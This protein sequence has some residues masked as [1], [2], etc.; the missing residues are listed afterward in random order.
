[1]A[2]LA[3]VMGAVSA[4]ADPFG[5]GRISGE[6]K[7][8]RVGSRFFGL[9]M[10]IYSPRWPQL[11]VPSVRM[12]TRW[13]LVEQEPGRYDWT[14]LDEQVQAAQV[15]GARPLLI[16][17]GTP[18][19]HSVNANPQGANAP[20]LGAYR[21]FVEALVA[22]YGEGV[23]YQ[24]WNEPN[25][26][27]F[28]SGTPA[29]AAEMT[30]LLAR[31]VRAAAPSATVVAPSF[32]LRGDHPAFRKWFRAYL[33]QTVGPRER[34]V[35]QFFDA[36][37][38]SA[39]PMPSGDPEDGLAIIRYARNVLSRHGFRGPVW[40]SE[41][42]YGAN[43]GAPAKAVPVRTQVSNVVR[44]YVLHATVG[45]DRVFWY[46]WVPDQTVNTQL[47]NGSGDL[48]PAGKAFGTVQTWLRSGK[49]LG[50]KTTKGVSTCG[51]R[52]GGGVKRY[53]SWTRSGRIRPLVAPEGAVSL[54]YPTSKARSLKPGRRLHVGVTP[55]MIE[56]QPA[57]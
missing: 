18:P 6:P 12:G 21:A 40:A 55:V 43:G 52:V 4:S 2:A 44:T 22:R 35:V 1:M 14:F 10:E 54:T 37:S 28:F 3:T 34:P 11:P 45:A 5:P 19:F 23:D 51:F 49:P 42:N 26:E 9:G 24:A 25:V 48:T 53:V 36:A 7:D 30:R 50:C 39:Y 33:R 29:R 16:V 17:N 20:A 31:A 41:I 47:Q 46:S 27:Q 32:P 57:R 8:A 15:R 56:V 38:I 13:P